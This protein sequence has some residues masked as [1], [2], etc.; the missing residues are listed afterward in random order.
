MKRFMVALSVPIALA[1]VVGFIYLNEMSRNRA[2]SFSS[3]KESAP[4]AV[5]FTLEPA[6]PSF[7]TGLEQLPASLQGTEVDGMLLAD[8]NGN[9]V[10]NHDI[11]RVFDY[12]LSTLGAESLA[13]IQQR[14]RSYIKDQLPVNAAQQAE[15][16][17]VKYMAL[18]QA[19]SKLELSNETEANTLLE[20][21]VLRERLLSIQSLRHEHLPTDV[22]GAFYADEDALDQL[23]LE[24][25]DIM[26]DNTLSEDERTKALSDLEESIPSHLQQVMSDLNKQQQLNTLTNHLRSNG[27]SDADIYQLRERIYGSEAAERLAQLDISRQQWQIRMTRWL[28]ERDSLMAVR[29][30]DDSDRQQQIDRLRRDYFEPDEINRVRILEGIHDG[31]R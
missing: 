30:L 20:T 25:I 12:F 9:L 27:G 11:R 31:N 26:Q 3:Q 7:I 21:A 17:L 23:A 5:E 14:L 1:A 4:S 19:L 16:L 15:Q 13:Q 29:G 18:N 22:I 2:E 24:R 8:E 6:P 28:H 10:I